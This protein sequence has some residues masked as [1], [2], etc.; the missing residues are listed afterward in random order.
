MDGKNLTQ[1]QQRLLNTLSMKEQT[2]GI[3]WMVIGCLQVLTLF[4]GLYAIAVVGVL[5]ISGAVSSFKQSKRVLQPYRGMIE[6]YDKQ[7]VS[8]IIGFVYNAIFG[9]IVGIAGNVY[10][11]LTR[12]FVLI[13]R[14]QIGEIEEAFSDQVEAEL[15]EKFKK[16]IDAAHADGKGALVISVVRKAGGAQYGLF[17]IDGGANQ[18]LMPEEAQVLA[19]EKG[20]HTIKFGMQT[21]NFELTDE[22]FE[23]QFELGSFGAKR[24]H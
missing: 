13:N 22:T 1:E 20:H 6:E 8:I 21:H 23:M 4:F 5:N 17:S 19:L 3:I 14:L 7:L 10:D 16:Q 12:N 24:V 2:S 11:L 9:G 15:K 18:R